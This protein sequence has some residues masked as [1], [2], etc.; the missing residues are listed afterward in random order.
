MNRAI[1]KTAFVAAWL[2]AAGSVLGQ[3][4][5]TAP[6]INMLIGNATANATPAAANDKI[7]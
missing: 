4:K 6:A 5:A 3:P 1:L 2:I 7:A